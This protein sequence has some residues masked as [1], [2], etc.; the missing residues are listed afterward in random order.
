MQGIGPVES[1]DIAKGYEI[2]TDT[3]VVLDNAEIDAVKL[4]SKKTIDLEQFV[5]IKDLDIRL[6]ERP[7]YIGPADPLASEGY[8]VIRDAMRETGKA[9]LAQVTIAGREWLVAVLP[10]DN[11]LVMEMLRY[12]D[13]I[14]AADDFF[15]DLP[16]TTPDREMVE[17]AVQLMEKKTAPFDASRF[18]DH[19]QT[20]LKAL[21]QEKLKGNRIV[22][23]PEDQ[24]PE[25]ANVIDL[26]EALRRSVGGKPP[27]APPPRK[28]SPPPPP[29]PPAAKSKPR[30]TRARKRA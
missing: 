1:A 8:A 25:G 14:R 16:A 6:F 27:P 20:A 17:L 2:D 21:V 24:R 3:Y 7:Y 10:M 19:Y 28:G 9:G 29:P 15:G 5:D 30:P 13:E 11:G 18:E 12:G 22:T 23:T 26:M 4:E